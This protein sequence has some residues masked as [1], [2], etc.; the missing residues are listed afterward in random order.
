[1][2]TPFLIDQFQEQQ[3]QQ[4]RVGWN[5]GRTG[6]S[7]LLDDLLEANLSEEWKEEKDA[8]QARPPALARV[9]LENAGVGS[10]GEIGLDRKGR[11]RGE[12]PAASLEGEKGGGLPARQPARNW[13]TSWR[14][15]A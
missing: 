2:T 5:G 6:I 10:V 8:G 11:W 4:S 14:K 3:T 13:W 15:A 12:R 1:M 9:E 7:G